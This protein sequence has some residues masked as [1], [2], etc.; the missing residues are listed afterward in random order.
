MVRMRLAAA[1]LVA[2]IFVS[3]AQAQ[4][5]PQLSGIGPVNRGMGGAATAAPLE[6]IGA[7]HWNPA[8]ISAFPCSQLSVGVE[9]VTPVT[10][11]S[12]SLGAASGN[13]DSDSGWAARWFIILKSL[14]WTNRLRG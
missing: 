6:A 13:T 14:F 12:S 2:L 8:T 10:D 7:L 5:G 3:T 11:I 9:V 1:L 4:I